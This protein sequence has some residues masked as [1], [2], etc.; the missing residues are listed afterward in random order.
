VQTLSWISIAFYCL[1][2]VFV[3][4]QQLH[5]NNSR[6]A[7]QGFALALNVSACAGLV[8][9]IAY[10]V[11]YGWSVAWWAPIVIF[12]IGLVSTIPAFLIERV[13][14]AA[15]LS[16]IAFIG[17]PVSAYFMFRYIPA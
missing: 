9:G 17:W 10:L 4:Y 2:G 11:Y 13:I 1:F 5:A 6:G 3:F 14:G 7:G 12:F 8:T 15:T 16:L